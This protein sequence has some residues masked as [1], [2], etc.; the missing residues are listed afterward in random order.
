MRSLL[1]SLPILATSLA[2]S[3]AAD[4][5]GDYGGNCDGAVQ[6]AVEISATTVSV[7][8]A[9]RMDYAKKKCVVSGTLQNAANGLAGEIRPGMKVFVNATPDGGI[10]LNGIPP[11]TCGRDLNGY[12]TPIGD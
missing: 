11:R 9:D 3:H 10:Y 5:S 4:L 8:V 1:L 6:C 2:P 7:I 12:Y